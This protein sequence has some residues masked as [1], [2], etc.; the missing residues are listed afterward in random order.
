MNS[1]SYHVGKI[2]SVPI[3]RF[4]KPIEFSRTLVPRPK[5]LW[6]LPIV[7]HPHCDGDTPFLRKGQHYNVDMRFVEYRIL[8]LAPDGITVWCENVRELDY[9]SLPCLRP[10]ARLNQEV[11]ELIFNNV[12]DKNLVSDGK[13][14]P[15]KGT[16]LTQ[17]QIEYTSEGEPF[18]R[19][20]AHGL[21]WSMNDGRLM[22][23]Y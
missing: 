20:P 8:K 2:Y 9:K 3:A 6:W 7:G 10:V 1:S 11:C 23:P 17:C 13:T 19:C 5:K 12:L 14:C 15:H 16:D 21:C 18:K 4:I 22:P